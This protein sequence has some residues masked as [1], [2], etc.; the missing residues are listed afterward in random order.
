MR[1]GFLLPGFSLASALWVLLFW[2]GVRVSVLVEVHVPLAV[3][4]EEGAPCAETV[5]VAQ[6]AEAELE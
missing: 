5:G 3:V 2:L 1:D 6:E 4:E